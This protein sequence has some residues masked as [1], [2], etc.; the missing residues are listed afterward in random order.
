MKQIEVLPSP[1]LAHI[2]GGA[3]RKIGYH[4]YL[5][6]NGTKSK[7]PNFGP[8]SPLLRYTTKYGLNIY[9]HIYETNM[10]HNY[11]TLLNFSQWWFCYTNI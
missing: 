2:E 8:G 1:L 3:L 7:D 9:I 5:T 11:G 6:L 10:Y 4:G